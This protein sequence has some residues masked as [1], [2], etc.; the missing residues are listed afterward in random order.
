MERLLVLG[1]AD[2]RRMEY[3]MLF[4]CAYAFLLR[5]PS[6]AVKLTACKGEQSVQLVDGRLVL[7]LARRKNKEKGSVLIRGCWCREAP[8]TCPVHVLGKWVTKFGV[9]QRI[10]PTATAS[11]A[12][13]VVREMLGELRTPRANEYR[14][15]DFRRGHAKDLQESGE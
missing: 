4:L 3:S 7:R 15:H 9:G 13:R 14:T 10:F 1:A 5:L 8:G 2:V 6:E 12:L 11:G